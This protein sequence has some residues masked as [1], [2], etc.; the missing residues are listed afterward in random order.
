VA[1]LSVQQLT[2]LA[3][4]SAMTA[5]QKDVLAQTLSASDYATLFP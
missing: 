5:D 3:N 2:D 4:R 1:A